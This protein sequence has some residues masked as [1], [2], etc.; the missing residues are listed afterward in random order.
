MDL[1]LTSVLPYAHWSPRPG[2]GVWGLFGA[3]WGDLKLR[4]EAGEVKTDLEMLLGAVGARQELLTWRRIDLALKADALLTELETRADDRL[5][6]TAGDVQRLPL[7]VE[8]HTAWGVGR[9]VPDTD[10]RDWGSV[11]RGQGGDGRGDGTLRQ[12]RVRA[13]EAGARH[14][15]PG[16]VLGGA[17]E[18]GV[19]RVGGESDAT[20]GSRPRPARAMASIGAGLGDGRESG[21]AVGGNAEVLRAH[22]ETDN[23]PG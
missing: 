18:G 1:T 7:M 10:G 20:D 23:A 17:P 13:P 12:V 6:K 19:R 21:R 8:G 9:V 16:A 14:R 3:G 11:G 2:L 4:D 15:S 5:S 22:T